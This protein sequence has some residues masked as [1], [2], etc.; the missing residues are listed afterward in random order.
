MQSRYCRLLLDNHSADYLVKEE[1]AKR[2]RRSRK[3]KQGPFWAC[4]IFQVTVVSVRYGTGSGS[5]L[6]L[7]E[8]RDQE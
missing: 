5:D 1:E 8:E 6:V 4:F 7:P 3:A 2:A